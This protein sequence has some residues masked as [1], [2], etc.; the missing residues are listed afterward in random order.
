[1]YE[2][3]SH[4]A[5]DFTSYFN[6]KED[7]LPITGAGIDRAEFDHAYDALQENGYVLVERERAW[8]E[9]SRLRSAYALPVNEL[10]RWLEIPPIQWVGDRSLL[11]RMH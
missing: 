3:G 5:R 1:M 6:L 9:F 11:S 4:L 8:D 10:A 7:A 2:I